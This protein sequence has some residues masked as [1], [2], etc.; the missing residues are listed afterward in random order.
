MSIARLHRLSSRLAVALRFAKRD[1]IPAEILQQIQ[2]ALQ[3]TAQHIRCGQSSSPIICDTPQVSSQPD[4]ISRLSA[5]A[6]EFVPM[7]PT[8]VGVD[9]FAEAAATTA[10]LLQQLRPSNHLLVQ[11]A[12]PS[13]GDVE[14]SF[15]TRS[16]VENT[17]VMDPAADATDSASEAT[18]D[19]LM[20]AVTRIAKEHFTDLRIPCSSP[21]PVI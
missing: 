20:D 18:H 3:M 21:T 1:D 14:Q 11:E 19:R 2:D 9:Y 13:S 16:D 5:H 6:A 12:C 7:L 4:C 17:S 8:E 10:H 15:T